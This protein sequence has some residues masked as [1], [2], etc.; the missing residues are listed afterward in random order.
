M[1]YQC[2]QISDFCT[3]TPEGNETQRPEE[4]KMSIRCIQSDGLMK[5]QEVEVCAC[6]HVAHGC[7]KMGRFNE[8]GL[9][10]CVLCVILVN[11]YRTSRPNPCPLV[12]TKVTPYQRTVA[13]LYPCRQGEA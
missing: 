12:P 5:A 6:E 10:G 8:I 9:E 1:L 13:I 11:L 2:Q 7:V 3:S 4:R